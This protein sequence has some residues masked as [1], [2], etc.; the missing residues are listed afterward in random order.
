MYFLHTIGAL[1][2]ERATGSLV[3]KSKK[4]HFPDSEEAPFST[5]NISASGPATLLLPT[6]VKEQHHCLITRKSQCVS[7]SVLCGKADWQKCPTFTHIRENTPNKIACSK[8]EE[9]QLSKSREPDSQQDY[10]F[11]NRRGAALQISRARLPTGLLSQ[12]LNRYCYSNLKSQTPN[13]IA[14]SKIE[15]APLSKSRKPNSQRIMCLK[16][17]EAPSSESRELDSQ[18]DY[19]LKNQRDIALQISRVRLPTGLLSQKLKRH[20]SLNLES[21]IPDK[22]SCS[23]TEEAPLSELREPDFL[24]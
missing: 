5:R 15:E 8:I 13:K 19:F 18:Q 3:Q 9:A 10:M 17:E 20:R 14:F 6:R 23:K 16:I 7:T 24:G 21:Q 12:K 4:H 11:K 2:K 22:I 1:I